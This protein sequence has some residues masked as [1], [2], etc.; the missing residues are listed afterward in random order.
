MIVVKEFPDRQF[1]N[2][3]ELFTALRENKHDIIATKK[4]IVKEADA[5]IYLPSVS[6]DKGQTLKAEE[7]NLTDIDKIQAK[8]VINTTLLM[9]SHSD[10]HLNGIWKKSVKETKNP[11]LLQEHK[12]TF[13]HIISDNVKAS[14]SLM[15]WTDLGFNYPGST[16]ALVFDATI[17]KDRNEFMFNQYAKGYVKEHSVGM[18]YVKIELGINSD[19]RYDEEEK[20]VWDKYIDLVVNKD[21]AEERGYAWFVHEA[22]IIEGSAVVKGSNFATPTISVEAAGSTSTKKE[23]SSDT[24][25]VKQP[26]KKSGLNLFIQNL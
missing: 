23:P 10:V 7:T 8:L 18:R 9:D 13:D 21:L 24:Q 17:S 4:M 1:N 14:V 11:Y 19:N 5:I 15:P 3:Q 6:S 26:A 2:K 16:E 22:K 20:K 12:M 25:T